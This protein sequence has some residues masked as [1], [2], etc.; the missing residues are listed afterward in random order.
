MEEPS[1]TDRGSAGEMWP[2]L[3]APETEEEGSEE[4]RAKS[5]PRSAGPHPRPASYLSCMWWKGW[6][7]KLFFIWYLLFPNAFLLR[8]YEVTIKLQKLPLISYLR[9]QVSEWGNTKCLPRLWF[10]S[11]RK[12][13]QG[14]KGKSAHRGEHQSLEHKASF[15]SPFLTIF[16]KRISIWGRDNI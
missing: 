8:C 11:E 1:N 15:L 4:N 14:R 6:Q 16:L 5:R 7:A 12:K 10:I 9:G 13:I 3:Q 2:C